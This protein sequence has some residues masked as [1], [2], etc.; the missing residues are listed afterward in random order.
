MKGPRLQF[1]T[2]EGGGGEGI[3]LCREGVPRPCGKSLCE[4]GPPLSL[5]Q[6]TK[7]QR[8]G[9]AEAVLGQPQ[10]GSAL[11]LR[12]SEAEEKPHPPSPQASLHRVQVLGGPLAQI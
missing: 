5:W 11:G 3:P 6:G 9:E 2:E 8:G 10:G 7:G 1:L 12:R 4:A